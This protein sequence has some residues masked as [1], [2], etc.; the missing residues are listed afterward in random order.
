MDTDPNGC[1]EAFS[2]ASVI[3][4]GSPPAQLSDARRSVGLAEGLPSNSPG[5][6]VHR[7]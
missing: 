2:A 5:A 3:L 7:P 6:K 1:L 4:D